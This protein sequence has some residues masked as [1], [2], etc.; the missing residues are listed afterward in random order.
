[1]T[2]SQNWQLTPMEFQPAVRYLMAFRPFKSA[3]TEIGIL[4]WYNKIV[5]RAELCE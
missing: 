2:E 3:A 1:M 4:K 5:L